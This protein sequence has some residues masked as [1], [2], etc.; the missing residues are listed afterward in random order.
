MLLP[1]QVRQRYGLWIESYSYSGYAPFK[2]YNS[3]IQWQDM[4]NKSFGGAPVLALPL[5][6][7][8][9]FKMDDKA[10]TDVK[11]VTQPNAKSIAAPWKAAAVVERIKTK[12]KPNNICTIVVGARAYYQ[13]Q[14][15]VQ[16]PEWFVNSWVSRWSRALSF[17]F[18]FTFGFTYGNDHLSDRQDLVWSVEVDTSTFLKGTIDRWSRAYAQTSGYTWVHDMVGRTITDV[19]F[20]KAVV[21]VK[22]KVP[23]VRNDSDSDHAVWLQVSLS[24]QSFDNTRFTTGPFRVGD[25]DPLAEFELVSLDDVATQ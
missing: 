2:D 21:T 12:Y 10:S 16:L 3:L 5:L 15:E 17:R 19:K 1:A 11:L 25:L 14:F 20:P 9:D 13:G 22:Y 4:P 24:C 18:D 8:C 23:W 7:S 6:E